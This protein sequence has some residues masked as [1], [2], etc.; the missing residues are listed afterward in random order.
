MPEETLALVKGGS[1][2][3]QETSPEDVFTPE[4]FTEEHRMIA[5]TAQQFME[6]EVLPRIEEM[7]NKEE[8]KIGRA[9][10]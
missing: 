1:F 5:Q 7:E 10:V 2:L 9:H 8:G 4:D 6:N 3:I